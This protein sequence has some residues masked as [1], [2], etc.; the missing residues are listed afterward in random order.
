MLAGVNRVYNFRLLRG[1]KNTPP[2]SPFPKVAKNSQMSSWMG[3]N[4]KEMQQSN[5]TKQK[6]NNLHLWVHVMAVA[7]TLPIVTWAG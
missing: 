5:K 2:L 1:I 7:P 4:N 3:G 6:Q